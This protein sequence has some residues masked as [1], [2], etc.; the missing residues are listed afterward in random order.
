[1][2]KI[3]EAGKDSITPDNMELGTRY[4]FF[5]TSRDLKVGVTV[6]VQGLG[7]VTITSLKV[8]K[9]KD[10]SLAGTMKIFHKDIQ[11]LILKLPKKM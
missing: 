8:G 6:Y 1:M 9:A 10:C 2:I 4:T 11:W 7:I 3:Y 5:Q